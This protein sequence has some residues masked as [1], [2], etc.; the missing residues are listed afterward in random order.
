MVRSFSLRF[1]LQ[2]LNRDDFL[3][4][5]AEFCY[6]FSFQILSFLAWYYISVT[7]SLC[8][9]CFNFYIVSCNYLWVNTSP[10]SL[11]GS[12]WNNFLVKKIQGPALTRTLLNW[13]FKLMKLCIRN[14]E[15]NPLEE[16]RRVLSSLADIVIIV[17]VL[18]PESLLGTG[19]Y[20]STTLYSF[21]I[22]GKKMSSS[23]QIRNE[24]AF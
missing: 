10:W 4:F 8:I 18:C 3:G 6:P 22:T 9:K 21:K 5:T 17:I 2:N 19:I 15:Q 12:Q 16:D 13:D 23:L 14:E 1:V 11:K 24:D 7:S 20:F